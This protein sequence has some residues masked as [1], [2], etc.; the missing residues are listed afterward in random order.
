M[1]VKPSD[2]QAVASASGGMSWKTQSYLVGV[3][4]GLLLGLL[5]AYLYVRA[6][7]E[8]M[9]GDRPQRVKTGDLMKLTLALLAMIRQIADLGDR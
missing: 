5:S 1:A 9:T 7:E 4:G 6:T 3:I 2:P 8:N